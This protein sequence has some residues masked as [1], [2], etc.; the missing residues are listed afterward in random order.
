MSLLS[1]A[2]EKSRSRGYEYY[3]EKMVV[4]VKQDG[5]QTY[6]GAVCGGGGAEYSVYIDLEHP[7]SSSC[8]CPHAAGRW[9]IC[10]HIIAAYFSLFPKEAERYRAEKA[11]REERKRREREV[12]ETLEQKRDEAVWEYLSSM[13]KEELCELAFLL[14]KT[15][16]AWRYDEFIDDSLENSEQYY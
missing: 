3:K 12:W 16:P 13:S 5:P 14:L 6:S 11:E 8:T 10:K 7:R 2:S 9:V 15:G 4:S 1:I